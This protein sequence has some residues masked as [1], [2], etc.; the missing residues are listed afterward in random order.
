[1]I[2]NLHSLVPYSLDAK[3]PIFDCKSKDGLRGAHLSRARD[4]AQH[5]EEVVET[6]ENVLA[7]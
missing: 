1:M 5:F 4:S 2:P 7:W 6:I 3:K